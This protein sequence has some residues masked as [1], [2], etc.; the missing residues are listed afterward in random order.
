M[1]NIK[2]DFI[3]GVCRPSDVVAVGNDRVVF[4]DI[5]YYSMSNATIHDW[6]FADLFLRNTVRRVKAEYVRKA[7]YTHARKRAPVLAFGPFCLQYLI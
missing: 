3:V 7:L 5:L 1:I 2:H 4:C 6:M